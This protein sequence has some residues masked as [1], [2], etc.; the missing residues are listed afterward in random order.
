MYFIKL[1][2]RPKK[3][4]GKEFFEW[5]CAKVYGQ[6]REI[7]V[8]CAF[9]HIRPSPFYPLTTHR[10]SI[11]QA[12]RD[13][14]PPPKLIYQACLCHHRVREIFG[15]MEHVTYTTNISPRSWSRSFH[16]CSSK[17]LCFHRHGM[18][19]FALRGRRTPCSH[20]RPPS[21]N[22]IWRPRT[23]DLWNHQKQ[24][25]GSESKMELVYLWSR[26]PLNQ[27]K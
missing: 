10:S 4:S 19:Q 18:F 3:R 14:S 16:P 25:D 2:K 5:D 7:H 24:F 15:G 22:R 9:R 26:A 27:R 1:T 20:P 13:D 23:M 17:S 11:L 6:N 12:W 8:H 21:R